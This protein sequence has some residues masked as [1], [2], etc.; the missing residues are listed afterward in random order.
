MN[1]NSKIEL[2]KILAVKIMN[3]ERYV[4]TL[5]TV[6][7]LSQSCRQDLIV[8]DPGLMNDGTTFTFIGR[9]AE[10]SNVFKEE[11]HT[12]VEYGRYMWGEETLKVI[13]ED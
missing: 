1:E 7:S 6:L 12:M 10:R 8:T 11:I 13:Y 3:G 5:K 2:G 4:E 9:N